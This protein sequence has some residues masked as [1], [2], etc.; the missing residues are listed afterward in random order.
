VTLRDIHRV[1]ALFTRQLKTVMQSSFIKSNTEALD[2]VL[3][4]MCHWFFWDG[5]LSENKKNKQCEYQD[6]N[7]MYVCPCIVVYA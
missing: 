1:S 5:F 7:L 6:M 3:A 4:G 2:I